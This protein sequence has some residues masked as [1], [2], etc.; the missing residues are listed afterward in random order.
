MMMMRTRATPIEHRARATVHDAH[1]NS[2]HPSSPRRACITLAHTPLARIFHP[3]RARSARSRDFA[4]IHPSCP[5]D[6][7]DVPKHTYRDEAHRF[8]TRGGVFVF[9]RRAHRDARAL[10]ASRARGDDGRR[11]DG[12]RE[13]AGHHHHRRRRGGRVVGRGDVER[14]EGVRGGGRSR[15]MTRR[16]RY[17][18]HRVWVWFFVDITFHA[19]SVCILAFHRPRTCS[20]TTYVDPR[21]R[22]IESR[23]RD[24]DPTTSP[25]GRWPGWGWYRYGSRLVV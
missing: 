10:S 1:T 12:R 13:N 24:R 22:A 16:L 3:P 14:R 15:V 11:D 19:F 20:N 23:D 9:T 18:R 7:F 2:P 8:A 6:A 21:A 17:H 25:R 4:S 5:R